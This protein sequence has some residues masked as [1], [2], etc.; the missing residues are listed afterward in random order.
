MKYIETDLTSVGRVFVSMLVAFSYPILAQPGRNSV[1][2]LWRYTD[3]EEDS[4]IKYN[5][6]RYIVVT[7]VFL[8]ATLLTAMEVINICILYIYLL[9]LLQ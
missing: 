4:W 2:G 7:A 8:G 5:K 6:F 9:S 3:K 1:L